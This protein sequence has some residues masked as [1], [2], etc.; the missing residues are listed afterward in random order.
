V[1]PEVSIIV[2]CF[3]EESTI[4]LLL[5][6]IHCQ[7]YPL[8]NL[9]VVV[10][11][12]ISTDHTKDEIR[13]FSIV[14]PDLK[15]KVVDNL[16][17]T[18]PA[19]I[20]LAVKNSEGENIIRLDAHSIPDPNYVRLCLMDLKDGKG[21][22]VG[23]V[24]DIKP[25]GK[26]WIALSIATAAANPLAVGDAHYRFTKHAQEVDTV[27]FGA[28]KKSLFNSVGGFDESLLTNEDYEFFTRIRKSGGKIWLDPAIR[29]VY[30]A[31]PTFSDLAYQY[32]RYGF[33]KYRMLKRYPNSIRWRQALPPLF[34]S[35]LLILLITFYFLPISRFLLLFSL[36]FYFFILFF[37]GC[38]MAWKKKEGLLF[39][40]IPI[41]IAI[42]HGCWGS[43]LLYSMIRKIIFR[44]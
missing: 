4:S 21:D 25:G 2:P 38:L 24:W 14:H 29:C 9:E 40:G 3:N 19:G 28:F 36:I 13:K 7:T 27:P 5:K 31:R 17:Q 41:A 34:V 22:C 20:N 32:W 16:R 11:D 15:I 6:A 30:F 8:Q 39:L 1:A 12:A 10:A 43:G 44:K 42:M 26:G 35:W 18:I 37:I 33:W 23:G